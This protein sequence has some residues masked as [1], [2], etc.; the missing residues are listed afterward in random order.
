MTQIEALYF[1]RY[2][3]PVG[4][5]EVGEWTLIGIEFVLEVIENIRLIRERLKMS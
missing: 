3:Y 4:L 5:F 2:R 1:R